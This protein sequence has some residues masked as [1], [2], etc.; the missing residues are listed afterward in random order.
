MVFQTQ[1]F[2]NRAILR[3]PDFKSAPLC[4]GARYKKNKKCSEN[5]FGLNFKMG[6]VNIQKY[7]F[8][9]PKLPCKLD[10]SRKMYFLLVANPKS[11]TITPPILKYTSLVFQNSFVFIVRSTQKKVARNSNFATRIFSKKISIS[12]YHVLMEHMECAQ[13]VLSP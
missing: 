10:T 4:F 6:G 3:P 12:C 7:C 1:D 2:P 13:S 9:F 8:L 11:L 5:T